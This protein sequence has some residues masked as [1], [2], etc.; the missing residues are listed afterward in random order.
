MST[1]EKLNE[2]RM[3]CKVTPGVGCLNGSNDLRY[4]RASATVWLRHVATLKREQVLEM[5][6][7]GVDDF[8]S[9]ALMKRRL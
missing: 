5:D 1:E 3:A 2:L 9:L 4:V 8:R 7:V 6:A